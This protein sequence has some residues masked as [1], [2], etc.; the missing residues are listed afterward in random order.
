MYARRKEG[1]SHQ[2]T[3]QVALWLFAPLQRPQTKGKVPT[4]DMLKASLFSIVNFVPENSWERLKLGLGN[5]K[6]MGKIIKK[7]QN[8]SVLIS[9]VKYLSGNILA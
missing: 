5:L 2:G 6:P 3:G 4:K 9:I 7:H 8:A 1:T